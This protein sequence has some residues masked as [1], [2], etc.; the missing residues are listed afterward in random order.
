[1]SSKPLT[2]TTTR[3]LQPHLC[4]RAGDAS[5]ERTH[6]PLGMDAERRAFL[7]HALQHLERGVHSG[8]SVANPHEL[9]GTGV[10]VRLSILHS[11]NSISNKCAP[12]IIVCKSRDQQALSC[13]NIFR[14]DFFLFPDPK[15][16]T[17]PERTLASVKTVIDGLTTPTLT[18]H[19]LTRTVGC[20][21]DKV[22][23]RRER[24]F[25]GKSGNALV[26]KFSRRAACCRGLICR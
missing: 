11:S 16:S 26:P 7:A 9:V 15:E 20:V 12:H 24:R 10:H 18:H 13:K 6:G 23:V 8:E 1:M 17:F 25:S 4:G 19:L 2:A 22:C 14:P 3:W 21:A 5:G